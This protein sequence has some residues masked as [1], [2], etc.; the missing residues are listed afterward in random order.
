MKMKQMAMALALLLG[1]A[2]VEAQVPEKENGN[3]RMAREIPFDR[4]IPPHELEV[5]YEKTVHLLFPSEVRYVDLGSPNIIAG[6]AEDAGNVIRVKAAVRNYKGETNMSVITEDGAFYSFNVRYAEEPLMTNIE[7]KDFIHDGEAVNRPNNARQVYLRELGSESPL[8]VRL[9]MKSIWK[10]DRRL[11][12]HVGSRRFGVQ[13]RL[14][15]IYA[16]NGLLYFH[17]EIRNMGSIP[18][19]IDYITWKIVDRKVARRTAVQEQVVLPLRAQN[20]VTSIAGYSSERTVFAM[21]KF[22]IPDDKHLVV[23][24]CEKNGG[25]HQT[26]TIENEDLVR[27]CNI[28]ELIIK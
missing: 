27:A 17:T 28:E 10:E 1:A 2:G 18:F 3:V 9:I 5:S 8:L 13:F 19:D 26:F 6:K 16:H 11:V 4:M 14:K 15:G 25:R 7:M 24:L 22:T 12:K 20:N 23:E 21:Q